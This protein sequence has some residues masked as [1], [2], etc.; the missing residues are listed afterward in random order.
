MFWQFQGDFLS[1]FTRGN[2]KKSYLDPIDGLRSIANLSIIL[3]HLVIMFSAFVS[4][5]PNIEWQQFLTTK[6]FASMNILA[7][8]LEIFFM[9]SAFLST[10]RL[11]NQWNQNPTNFKSFLR[12]EYPI[13]IIKRAFRFWPGILLS[14]LTLFILGEP[15]YPNSSYFFEFFRYFNIWMFFQNYINLEYYHFSLVPLWSVSLDMQT[16]ILLPLLLYLLYSYRKSISVYKCLYI[17][18]LI[19]IIRGMIVFDPVTMPM[20][21]LTYRSSILPIT[22]NEQFVNWVET[23][24]NV[25]FSSDFPRVNPGISFMHKMYFPLEARFGSFIIGAILAIKLIESSN[26]DK[27]PKRFKKYFFLG[28]ICFQMLTLIQNSNI[29]PPSD[30]MLTISIASFRQLYTIGQAFI[31]FTA[32]C[33]PTHPYHS[34]WIKTFLSSSIWIPISKLSYLV[35]VI[36]WRISFELIFGGPLNIL[37]TYSVTYAA[38][39]SLPIVLFITQLI[40]CIWYVL[41]EKP[42]ERVINY[43][44]QKD[45]LS[46]THVK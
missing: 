36:H 30:L 6:A 3:L 27:K 41:A 34:P 23:D 35:Y 32:L 5:Y 33:P 37:K 10:Y 39:I 9:L 20:H 14:T 4:P 38:L 24:Y 16:H 28:L 21:L 17:L 1:L 13:S 29:P 15:S 46:K 22:I 11:I 19:S 43:Y 2:D 42:I 25:T 45:Q 12:K 26:H 31:L 44:F 7:F 40:S 8:N 18:L